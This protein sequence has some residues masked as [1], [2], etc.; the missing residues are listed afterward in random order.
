MFDDQT[1]KALEEAATQAQ[2]TQQKLTASYGGGLGS[3][4]PRF[5]GGSVCPQ[6]GYCPHCGRRSSQP[7]YP[8]NPI[9]PVYSNF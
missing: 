7:F 3:Y 5:S 8:G 6:C 2:E 1:K 4:Q 9:G